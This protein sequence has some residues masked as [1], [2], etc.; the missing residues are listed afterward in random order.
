MNFYCNLVQH[1]DDAVGGIEIGIVFPQIDFNHLIF[2][3]FDFG[4]GQIE[5]EEGG[6][7]QRVGCPFAWKNGPLGNNPN[8]PFAKR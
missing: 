2:L 3:R 7:R 6:E 8:E 4:L 5:T 1:L